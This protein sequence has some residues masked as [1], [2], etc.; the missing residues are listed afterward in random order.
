MCAS[1]GVADTSHHTHHEPRA[2]QV[3]GGK[4]I[5]RLVK[6]VAARYWEEV[7][8]AVLGGRFDVGDE[9]CGCVL[10][11][12]YNEDILSIWNKS[13]DE[14]DV[15]LAIRDTL[16][17]VMGALA[18]LAFSEPAS[19]TPLPPPTHP[20]APPHPPTSALPAQSCRRARTWNIRSIPTPSAT[21]PPTATPTPTSRRLMSARLGSARRGSA[22]RGSA[23]PGSAAQPQGKKGC[24]RA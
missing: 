22:R 19:P 12:R 18:D 10:S 2:C 8:M 4:W 21:T 17:S 15:C 24:L 7:L 14:R 6:G 13:A 5:V 9:I 20:L 16:R 11:V 1:L 23:R 3:N